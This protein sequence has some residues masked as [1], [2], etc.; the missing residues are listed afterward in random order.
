MSNSVIIAIDVMGGDKGPEVIISGAA[1][2]KERH[3]DSKYIFFGEN[4]D[5]AIKIHVF[6]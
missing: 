4:E 1:L 6:D 5:F 3:P 2:S